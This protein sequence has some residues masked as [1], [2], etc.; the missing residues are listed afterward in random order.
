MLCCG[1][2][3]AQSTHTNQGFLTVEGVS[4][5]DQNGRSVILNGL[6]HV[7]KNPDQDYLDNNDEEL[8]KQ[9]KAWGFNFIRYGI[10]WD[11]LEP[12][13]GVINEAYL[14]EIDKRVAWAE[15][16]GIW[17]M[18]DMHQDLYGRKFGNGAPIWATLDQELPHT[19]GSVWSDAYFLSAAVQKSFDNFW[20]NKPASD[21]I[22]I[23]DHY[24]N[25]WKILAERYANSSAVAGFDLM[26]EPFMG[27][28]ATEVLG[29][30]MAGY[31][32]ILF[33]T[34][35]KILREEEVAQFLSDDQMR[36]A[37]LSKLNDKALYEILLTPAYNLVDQFEKEDLSSFYQKTRDA[38]R[39]V[40]K[41]QIIFLEHNYF[42]NLGVPSQFKTPTDQDGKA[43]ALCAYAPHG[44]DLTTD[45]DGVNNPNYERVDY[46]FNQLFSVASKKNMPIL[47]GEWGAY[48]MGENKYI[49][50][51]QQIIKL[52]EKN[53]SGQ[54]YWCY[55]NNIDH[56]DY[57]KVVLSRPYPMFTSG[58]LTQYENNFERK[59][60]T[61]SWIENDK[62]T[63][64]TRIFIPNLQT[65]EIAQVEL[66]PHSS[67]K[68]ERIENQLGGYLD[69]APMGKVCDREIIIQY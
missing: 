41:R 31:G 6:N 7:N 28:K 13:P 3:F 23:Q 34:E 39:S 12:E 56:Q 52:I 45:T 17:L 49:N 61:C 14:K 48:Y 30:L 10:H 63:S 38:I 11:A 47:I 5:I 42:C 53:L 26:N 57:F 37:I 43:D 55:W 1:S 16:A 40:N 29:A 66:K 27:S 8:F 50:P 69:I 9:F 54:S 20:R 35:G 67:I 15:E 62:I 64:P 22:G 60:L 59:I 58:V 19:T 68:V 65:F 25:L 44:Y 4:F 46:I 51:A 36:A 33:E 21:G 18:L 2:V 32:A 24:I